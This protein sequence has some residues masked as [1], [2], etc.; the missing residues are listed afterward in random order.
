MEIENKLK[1]ILWSKRMD[2]KTLAE[3]T[4]IS[5]TTITMLAN[6]KSEPS[7][8]RAYKIAE[9]LGVSVYDIWTIKKPSGE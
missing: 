9:V 7:L 8:F 1:V 3:A 4:G 6:E 2:Q 5:R